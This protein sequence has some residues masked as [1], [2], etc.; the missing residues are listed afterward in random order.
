MNVQSASQKIRNFDKDHS[1]NRSH[2]EKKG[3]VASIRYI[4]HAIIADFSP[5]KDPIHVVQYFKLIQK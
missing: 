1:N 4:A 3:E 5:N 2:I